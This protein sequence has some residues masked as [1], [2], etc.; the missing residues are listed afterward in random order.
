[1]KITPTTSNGT[2]VSYSFVSQMPAV[3]TVDALGVVTAVKAGETDIQIKGASTGA[4]TMYPIVVVDVG[5]VPAADGCVADGAVSAPDGGDL[6]ALV[7]YYDKWMSSAHSDKTAVP[8]NNWNM[9]GMIPV[10]CAR[11]HSQ[12]GFIDYL[13]GDGT[14]VGKV[15]N[16]APVGSVV[17]CKTCHN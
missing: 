15:D 10:E 13:G 12:A 5:V 1:L 14:T 3:A 17:G 4:T 2:D 6:T 8:F 9:Q 11:C 7:P 16:P